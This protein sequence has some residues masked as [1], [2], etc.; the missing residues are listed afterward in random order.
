MIKIGL[1]D[2]NGFTGYFPDDF[3]A[4]FSEICNEHHAQKRALLF[5]FLLFN[6]RDASVIRA[7]GDRAYW[8]SLNEISG[9]AISVFALHFP[10]RTEKYPDTALLSTI[11][12]VLSKYFE[13]DND[14]STPSILFFQIGNNEVLA[15]YRVKLRSKTVEDTY[16][17]MRDVLSA[18]A[19]AVSKVIPENWSNS[20]EVFALAENALRDR[21]VGLY[22]Q[23]GIGTITS[24]GK[25]LGLILG[26]WKD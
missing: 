8:N 4:R 22:I 12:A 10:D 25:L 26:V 20:A 21:E 11:E 16:L 24:L 13:T 18:A 2:P 14:K 9:N 6:L 15:H 3:V 17:E 5:A 7:L 19:D 1:C 23:R